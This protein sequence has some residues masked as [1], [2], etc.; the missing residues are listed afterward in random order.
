MAK[1]QSSIN[2]LTAE[3]RPCLVGGNKAMFHRWA[4]YAN[5]IGQSPMIGGHPGGQV[6]RPVAIIEF[7]DGTVA[8]CSPTDVRFC[9][10]PHKEYCF[11][12][13]ETKRVYICSPL[14]GDI[15]ENILKA[16]EY[17]REAYNAGLV[18]IAPHIYFTQFLDDDVPAERDFGLRAGLEA[19]RLCDEL[20]VYG[21]PSEGMRAE[22]A[23]AESMGMPI[24]YK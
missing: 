5:V 16:C 11:D 24:I 18:S 13:Q 17:C 3:Y 9:D 1:L 23:K 8:E 14:R 10:P 7:E 15:E 4:A 12:K 19:L 2:I 22:I 6:E 20:W 21:E